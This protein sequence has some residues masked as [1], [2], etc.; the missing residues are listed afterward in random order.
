MSEADEQ[1]RVRKLKRRMTAG[2]VLAGEEEWGDEEDEWGE[3]KRI[4]SISRE[5]GVARMLAKKLEI[6][7]KRREE[8]ARAVARVKAMKGGAEKLKRAGISLGDGEEM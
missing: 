2:Q 3:E 5:R 6:L 7:E 4:E 8:I 1:A